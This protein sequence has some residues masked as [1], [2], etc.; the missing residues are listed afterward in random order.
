MHFGLSS[1]LPLSSLISLFGSVSCSVA[2]TTTGYAVTPAASSACLYRATNA[3]ATMTSSLQP[4]AVIPPFRIAYNLEAS[5]YLMSRLSTMFA[6]ENLWGWA[7]DWAFI[8]LLIVGYLPRVFNGPRGS[9]EV[10]GP[11]APCL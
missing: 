3:S 9:H 5:A 10:N 2:I 6:F 1:K 8:G 11:R 4:W 7:L